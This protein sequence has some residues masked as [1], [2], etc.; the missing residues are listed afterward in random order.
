MALKKD[1][2]VT[3][4]CPNCGITLFKIEYS[5]TQLEIKC[6]SCKKLIAVKV[7][8]DGTVTSKLKNK[9]RV[10]KDW[11]FGNRLEERAFRIFTIK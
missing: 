4:N 7:I 8:D 3:V 10:P 11:F 9:P 6:Q 2:T 5:N 1:A